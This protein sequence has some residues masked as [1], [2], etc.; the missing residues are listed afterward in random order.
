MPASAKRKAEKRR[1]FYLIIAA[2]MLYNL[3]LLFG[4]KDENRPKHS[5]E[6]E[7]TT[8]TLTK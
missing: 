4:S 7:F 5:S 8:S 1:V 6:N 2:A 3:I